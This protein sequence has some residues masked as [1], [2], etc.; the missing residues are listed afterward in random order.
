[1]L[2]EMLSIVHEASQAVKET[3]GNDCPV[4]QQACPFKN[5]LTSAG[6]PLVLE[7][8]TR[9]WSLMIS[10]VASPHDTETREDSSVNETV[11]DDEIDVGLALKLKEGTREAHQAAETVHFVREFI[12]GRV[13]REI[14]G[15]MVVNLYHVYVALEEALDTCWEHPLVEYMYF[16]DELK[17]SETLRQDAE[18]FWGPGWEEIKK[19]STVT[20]EYVKRLKELALTAPELLVPHSYTRYLGDLSGGQ[21]LKRAAIRGLKLSKDGSEG[22]NF[23]NFKRIPN[24]NNF[25]NMYRARLDALQADRIVADNMVIEANYAFALNTRMFQELDKLAG[26]ENDP[27][28]IASAEAVRAAAIKRDAALENPMDAPACP[29][30]VLANAGF[31]MPSDHPPLQETGSLKAPGTTERSHGI[32]DRA[33][34]EPVKALGTTERTHGIGDRAKSELEEK[35]KVSPTGSNSKLK[36]LLAHIAVI[37]FC[38]MFVYILNL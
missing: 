4:F 18:F 36:A 37:L 24:P 22:V 20:L 31:A 5:F 29:F 10:D 11:V 6:T 26:F 7:L 27:E 25:K 28:A 13:S 12:K 2:A 19:P 32:V 34:S 38:I 16:P 1:M 35:K 15:Q 23:Y 3:V 8:E 21:V 14:Y 33:K 30:A 9:S 17:R